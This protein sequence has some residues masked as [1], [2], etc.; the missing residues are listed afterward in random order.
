MIRD[1]NPTYGDSTGSTRL[2]KIR[3][4]YFL[5]LVDGRG[6]KWQCDLVFVECLWMTGLM[7]VMLTS[8]S[9]AVSVILVLTRVGPILRRRYG[10]E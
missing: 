3:L 8:Y 1:S 9:H 4:V 2:K 5:D 6:E 7:V 10:V